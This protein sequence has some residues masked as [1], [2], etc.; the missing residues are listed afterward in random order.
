M[1]CYVKLHPYRSE[2]MGTPRVPGRRCAA[3]TGSNHSNSLRNGTSGLCV[4]VNQLV[5]QAL[6]R[7]FKQFFALVS[8]C[9]SSSYS[10]KIEAPPTIG[11]NRTT[12]TWLDLFVPLALFLVA[13]YLR[14]DEKSGKLFCA[15][16]AART[17]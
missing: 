14:L 4:C 5:L 11:E 6:C 7:L 10:S 9:S 2:G 1:A 8:T 13:Y 12:G 16:V 17:S 3:S 15:P